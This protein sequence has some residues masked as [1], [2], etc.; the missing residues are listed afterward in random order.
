MGKREWELNR[1]NE[2]E[3]IYESVVL[4]L[5]PTLW[6]DMFHFHN[7]VSM[8]EVDRER[9]E[10]KRYWNKKISEEKKSWDSR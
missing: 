9:G 2:K 6:E 5:E 7:D 8:W 4:V 3:C 1:K 10:K